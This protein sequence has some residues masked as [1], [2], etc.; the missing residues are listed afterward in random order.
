[1]CS[2]SGYLNR[3]ENSSEKTYL[4]LCEYVVA[5]WDEHRA[6]VDEL[7]IPD[8]TYYITWDTD[9][10]VIWLTSVQGVNVSLRR[11]PYLKW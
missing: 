4:L 7:S 8:I 1:M 3:F 5:T 11:Y 2:G 6:P 9:L 10:S